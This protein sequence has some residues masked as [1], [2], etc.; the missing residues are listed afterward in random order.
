MERSEDGGEAG[1]AAGEPGGTAGLSSNGSSN[2][3]TL[4]DKP[5]V[6]PAAYVV[7]DLV[8]GNH[9]EL[10]RG[11]GGA[12]PY[13]AGRFGNALC[14]RGPEVG[15]RVIVRDY[16]KAAEGR[17]TVAAWV[18][19]TG[20]P[21]CAMIAN[22]WGVRVKGRDIT[23]QFHF[24]L[25]MGDGDI[26]A[27]VTQRNGQTA[28]V[29]EGAWEPLPMHSWQHVAM[30]A[31]GSTLHLYR[32]GKEVDSTPCDGVLLNPPMDG[33]GIGCRL[34]A[35]G[36]EALPNEPLWHWYW[37]GLIDELVIFNE[38]LS[39]RS[40]EL[41]YRGKSQSDVTKSRKED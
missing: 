20:K 13:V 31:D 7:F 38:A 39:D 40:I 28:Q 23:G 3:S 37:H 26:S 8:G 32:N 24:G 18:L 10:R 22:N 1:G 16:P 2:E 17:L 9:G 6:S 11:P 19:A 29:R 35:T 36:A 41:L 33:L 4:L 27:R 5:A 34:D 25:I 12:S 15:D 21:N 14:F 30:V